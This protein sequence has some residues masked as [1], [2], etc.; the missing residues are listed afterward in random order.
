[1]GILGMK[2]RLFATVL[3]A[4]L[5]LGIAVLPGCAKKTKADPDPQFISKHDSLEVLSELKKRT[6]GGVRYSLQGGISKIDGKT[7]EYNSFK[8]EMK[9]FI[10][11]LLELD[12]EY[13][14]DWDPGKLTYPVYEINLETIDDT[15]EDYSQL[16]DDQKKE[17]YLAFGACWS[18]GY[19]ITAS[20]D[21]LKCDTDFEKLCECLGER[22]KL[23]HFGFNTRVFSRVS[24][25]W[26]DKWDPENMMSL[27]DYLKS[28]ILNDSMTITEAEGWNAEFKSMDSERITV[29]IDNVSASELMYGNEDAKVF[30]KIDGKW[31][32][33]PQDPSLKRMMYT[34][35][36]YCLVEGD[37]VDLDRRCGY[38]P[39][40]EYAVLINLG[41]GITG[42]FQY[43]LAEFTV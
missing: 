43:D 6:E 1:M 26:H 10:D 38:L 31:Y 20:G 36:G 29:T 11:A 17:A 35:I 30:A 7:E 9:E 13:V 27:E 39:K 14:D 18:D 34:A 32:L 5:L 4:N 8:Y 15:V 33:V 37:S 16:T 42:Q 21:V 24:A 40:G 2:S 22:S 3:S 28:R 23:D 19:L 41:T 25:L 12:M